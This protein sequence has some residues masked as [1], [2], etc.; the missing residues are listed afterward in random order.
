MIQRWAERHKIASKTFFVVGCFFV[1]LTLFVGVFWLVGGSKDTTPS[2]IQGIKSKLESV[3]DRLGNI[4]KAI[5]ELT[6]EQ[7]SG[8]P[9]K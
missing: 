9:S 1:A 7:K 8:E 5:E 6:N 3:E 4:E 2:D